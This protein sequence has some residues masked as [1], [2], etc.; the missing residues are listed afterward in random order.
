MFELQWVWHIHCWLWIYLCRAIFFLGTVPF[1]FQFMALYKTYAP[2]PAAPPRNESAQIFWIV[3]TWKRAPNHDW[4]SRKPRVIKI[5]RIDRVLEDNIYGTIFH[6]KG[7]QMCPPTLPRNYRRRLSSS[8]WRPKT[9]FQPFIGVLWPHTWKMIVNWHSSYNCFPACYAHHIN[10]EV[11]G[12]SILLFFAAS[13]P[14]WINAG[15]SSIV[16]LLACAVENRGVCVTSGSARALRS[17][18][19]VSYS[20]HHSARG[21]CRSTRPMTSHFGLYNAS[22]SGAAQNPSLGLTPICLDCCK[23]SLLRIESDGLLSSRGVLRLSGLASRK[24]TSYG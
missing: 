4:I 11:C 7:G 22:L 24:R 14:K 17:S 21:L 6:A 10:W 12:A 16:P 2:E 19:S 20:C 1:H 13:A 3:F 15:R 23:P 5:C 18:S 9:L 8:A